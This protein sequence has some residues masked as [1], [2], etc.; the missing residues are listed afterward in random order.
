MSVLIDQEALLVQTPGL[1]PSTCINQIALILM[2]AA[3]STI[4][5]RDEFVRDAK[6]GAAVAGAEIWVCT[7]PA[8]A[9][10]GQSSPPSPLATLYTDSSGQETMLQPVVT[11]GTGH[12][13]FF[14]QSLGSPY[15][16]AVFNNGICQQV[17][18]DQS[19]PDDCV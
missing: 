3:N 16:I 19:I 12:C 9:V 6:T 14:V 4:I 15:T 2:T 17:Y 7:Q 13:Y 10:I 1:N 11:D 8:D 5:R 18:Q